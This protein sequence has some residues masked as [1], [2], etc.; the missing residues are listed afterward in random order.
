[1]SMQSG[2]DTRIPVIAV[3]GLPGSGKTRFL[4]RMLG[5]QPM[6]DTVVLLSAPA[7]PDAMPLAYPRRIVVAGMNPD[8]AT[9]CLCCGIRS[10]VGDAL[11][12]LFFKALSRRVPPVARVIVESATTDSAA[13]RFTLRHAPFLGQRYLLVATLLVLDAR[14]VLADAS[15]NV[16]QAG[17]QAA[18][19]VVL[20][21]C[22]LMPEADSASAIAMVQA[23]VPGTPVVLP[24]F[25]VE[26]L[27]SVGLH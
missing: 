25:G 3:I 13:L 8:P 17:V 10:G 20:S 6:H 27:A 2:R 14:V 18:D 5:A 9:G 22:D 19:C 1:M 21:H 16:A 26:A 23:R 12:E 7:R 11:R 24:D 4:N 15:C